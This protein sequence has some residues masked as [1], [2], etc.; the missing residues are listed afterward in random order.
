MSQESHSHLFPLLS[1]RLASSQ[2]AVT[3]LPA[4]PGWWAI[5]LTTPEKESVLFP[6]SGET[7]AL[8][9]F[10]SGWRHTPILGTITPPGHKAW[11]LV[12]CSHVHTPR[13][14]E[15]SQSHS[16]QK[17]GQREGVAPMGKPRMLFWEEGE[18]VLGRDKHL[19][20]TVVFVV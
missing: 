13:I 7:G 2:V 17:T 8:T 4:E 9:L 15:R 5:S 18:W 10:W 16:N 19:L 6:D 1:W 20:F 11:G 12:S 14:G 3:S